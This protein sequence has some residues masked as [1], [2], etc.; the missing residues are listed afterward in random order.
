MW[1][2]ESVPGSWKTGGCDHINV[3]ELRALL[4][5][6][7]HWA[8]RLRGQVVSLHVDNKTTVAYIMWEGGPDLPN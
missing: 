7:C 8:P 5:A 2:Q 4:L 1:G 3:L 6:L